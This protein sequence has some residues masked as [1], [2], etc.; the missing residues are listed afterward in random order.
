[1]SDKKKFVIYAHSGT[2][3]KL[4]QIITLAV[5]AASMGKE[6][7]IFLFFWAL[8]KFVREEFDPERLALEFGED[9][10][11]MA[12]RL[13]EV[14]PVPLNEI[15]SEVRKVGNLKIYACTG[16]VKIM[17]LEEAEVQSKVDDIM[18]L[19][20]LFEIADGADTQLFI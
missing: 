11:R 12:K 16:A 8:K 20:T 17:E 14:N 1:M 9:G 18:G 10:Q 7:Y 4:Y 6:T 13:Q 2:Y 5:T 19:T 15:L 3:D